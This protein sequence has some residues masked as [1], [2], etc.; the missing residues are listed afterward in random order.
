MVDE[1]AEEMKEGD[2]CVGTKGIIQNTLYKFL[3]IK[4]IRGKNIITASEISHHKCI[5]VYPATHFKFISKK[6]AVIKVL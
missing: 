1:K 5:V 6:E 4:K 3:K 2:Y